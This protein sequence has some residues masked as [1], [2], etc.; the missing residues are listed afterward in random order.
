MAVRTLSR[1]ELARIHD[2]V[3]FGGK[4]D[5]YQV[6]G[7]PTELTADDYRAIYRRGGIASRIVNAY[8]DA[9]WSRAPEVRSLVDGKPVIEE[10]QD[11]L[12]LA[13]WDLFDRRGLLS[14]LHRL[15]RLT[16][17]GHYGVLHIGI[18]DGKRQSEPV[19][20]GS[21]SRVLYLQP[22]GETTAQVRAW[23]YDPKSPRYGKPE[24]YALTK[25]IEWQGVGTGARTTEVHHSRVIHVAENA[26]E[27]ASIGTPRLEAVW[28]YLTDISK[29]TGSS[30]ETFWINAAMLIAFVAEAD[31]K[32][33]P[34]E[35]GDMK[36]QLEEMSHGLSRY[37]RLRGVDPQILTAPIADPKS[38]VDVLLDLCSG[39]CGIPK[40]ILVGSER[41]ELA[42]S[43][44]DDNW[45]SRNVERRSHF[46]EPCIVTPLVQRLQKFGALPDAPFEVWWDEADSLGPEK[47]ANI[48]V[49]KTTALRNYLGTPGA[50]DIIAPATMAEWLGEDAAALPMDEPL[51]EDDPLEGDD[52]WARP[53]A[54]PSDA[55]WVR[56]EPL[57]LSDMRSIAQ[58]VTAGEITAEQG[59]A[60]LLVAIPSLDEGTAR[61]I[62]G[63]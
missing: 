50:E 11:P 22:H 54:I 6:F 43:Q 35:T 63:A 30:A 24:M 1:A 25:G 29:I 52:Q 8:P 48:A 36:Q 37:L 38:H 16:Q 39:V 40:R 7:Y 2:G 26:M 10:K 59:L 12:R 62:V 9:T 42:S 34:E 58:S 27:N 57:P 15:D 14:T 3:L 56:T 46:V 61:K 21:A 41:G 55:R 51:P 49:Q 60:L 18:N 28:N 13:L 44:D 4:R 17:L 32:W 23:D 19:E 33:D 53:S 47:R 45:N 20:P 31:V 5:L